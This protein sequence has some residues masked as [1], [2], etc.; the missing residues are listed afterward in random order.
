MEQ[1]SKRKQALLSGT[2]RSLTK[3]GTLELG[4]KGEV[5]IYQKENNSDNNDFSDLLTTYDEPKS[6]L[7]TY[8]TSLI[9]TSITF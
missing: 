8:P 7:G 3:E 6:R 2:W 1:S 5:G 9:L 4:F